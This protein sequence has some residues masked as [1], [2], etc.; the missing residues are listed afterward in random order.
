MFGV[1][2]LRS[3]RSMTGL[4]ALLALFYLTLGLSAAWHAPHFS[5][6]E[7]AIGTDRHEQH[8][9]VLGDSCALCSTKNASHPTVVA[10][11]PE[12]DRSVGPAPHAL[13]AR[14]IPGSFDAFVARGPPALLS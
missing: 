4:R 6:G 13:V 10:G 11:A 5:Q 1:R 8:E 14:S 3:R 7:T 12:R 9:A 2:H